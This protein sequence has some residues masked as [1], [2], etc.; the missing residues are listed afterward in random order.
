MRESTDV[1]WLGGVRVAIAG[2]GMREGRVGFGDRFGVWIHKPAR[3][4]GSRLANQV[5]GD[6]SLRWDDGIAIEFIQ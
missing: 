3:S 1:G 6:V 2:L 5:I 4:G